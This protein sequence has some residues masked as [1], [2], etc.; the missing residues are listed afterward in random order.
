MS[1]EKT[2]AQRILENST[3]KY[4]Q[5]LSESTFFSR[6]AIDIPTDVPILNVAL[7]SHVDKGLRSG[8]LM[9]SGK[10]KRFKTLFGLYMLSA[11]QKKFKDGVCIYYDSEFGSPPSYLERFGLDLTRIVHTP[12]GTVENLKHDL[13]VQLV[14]LKENEGSNDKVLIFVDSIGNLASKKEVTDAL[15]GSEKADMTRAKQLKSLFRIIS[16]DLN[17]LDIPFLCINHTYT[18]QGA[19]NPKYAGEVVSGGCVVSGTKVR[20]FDNTFKNIEEIQINDLVFTKDGPK[21]V[22][23]AWTPDTLAQGYT[24]CIEIEFEDGFKLI[25][26]EDHKLLLNSEWKRVKDLSAG[27]E[28]ESI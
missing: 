2:L 10:S 16:L 19:A 9:I 11:F 4:S 26:S 18:D 23:N 24:D 5:K 1:K 22:L 20:M 13:T 21:K 27:D 12:I 14:K 17:I 7:S 15:E 3:S 25:C 28:I 8:I 6:D